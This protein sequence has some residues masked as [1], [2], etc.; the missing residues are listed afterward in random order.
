MNKVV[1]NNWLS[2]SAS[3][4]SIICVGIIATA[5]SK[6][7]PSEDASQ[8]AVGES[9][10]KPLSQP[11]GL[12]KNPVNHNKVADVTQWMDQAS[13]KTP[14]QLAQ[15][16]KI[17]KEKEA[18]EKQAQEAKRALESKTQT[19]KNETN[20]PTTQIIAPS[21]GKVAEKQAEQTPIEAS[22]PATVSAMASKATPEPE[23]IVLKLI[24]SIQPKFPLSAARAGIT[25]GT[26]S[27][28]IHI[29]TDGKVSQVEILKALPKKVFEK[30]VMSTLS[31][32]KYAPI[33]KP[34]T[35]VFEFNF[36]TDQ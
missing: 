6:N 27:A 21:L 25:E 11:T 23:R 7:P 4:L 28:K 16:E 18:K 9:A 2:V 34:Q 22:A 26:V 17:A 14:A 3:V 10:P 33:S 12:V 5:C 1:Q 30:E 15:E 20:A 19:S 32:W 29:E 13:T 36:K 31:Q 35:A 8:T 24:N